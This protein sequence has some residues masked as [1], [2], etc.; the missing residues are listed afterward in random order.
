MA[1][2]TYSQRR[3]RLKLVR[4]EMDKL[5]AINDKAE[6][7]DNLLSS[8]NITG[9]T[10]ATEIQE[11]LDVLAARFGATGEHLWSVLVRQ[12]L[13]E[14]WM[15]FGSLLV[16]LVAVSVTIPLANNQG[17]D[18]DGPG[19]DVVAAICGLWF[20]VS[21]VVFGTTGIPHLLNPEFYALKILLP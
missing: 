9:I 15:I 10:V 6:R 1:N 5:I 16:A 13:I 3:S 14:G 18:K 11:V 7:Q 12:Q 2:L 21:F 8:Q 4:D 20:I 17:W 19:W